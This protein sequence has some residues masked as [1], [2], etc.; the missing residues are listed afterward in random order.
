LTI[1]EPGGEIHL[2]HVIEPLRAPGDAALIAVVG[3]VAAALAAWGAATVL[4]LAPHADHLQV[5]GLGVAA[6]ATALTLIAVNAGLDVARRR[7]D[8]R[9]LDTI[10]A[11]ARTAHDETVDTLAALTLKVEQVSAKVEN[12]Y[13]AGY[14]AG[15][16]DVR[17][18]DGG[19]VV[20][21][22]HRP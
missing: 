15:A 14:S 3:L 21:L 17:G 4:I 6:F 12:V 16:T 7:R 2:E 19:T 20:R 18:G 8:G 13:W 10:R 5:I 11:L 22:P 9:T 1:T